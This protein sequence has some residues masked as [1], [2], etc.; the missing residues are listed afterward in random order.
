MGQCLPLT[1]ERKR[2]GLTQRQVADLM[3]VSPGRVSQIENGDLGER[4]SDVEPLRSGTGGSD[5]DHLRLR[6][7]SPSDRVSCCRSCIRATCS[8]TD[9]RGRLIDMTIPGYA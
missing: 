3:G 8:A 6:K 2:L 1:E 9:K 5:A 4:G 7:R